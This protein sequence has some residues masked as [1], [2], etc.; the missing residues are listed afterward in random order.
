MWNIWT[1]LSPCISSY[2]LHCQER[3]RALLVHQVSMKSIGGDEKDLVKIIIF[4]TPI[5]TRP[6][7][8][9]NGNCTSHFTAMLITNHMVEMLKTHHFGFF[10]N[11]EDL[12]NKEQNLKKK[13][14]TWK[15]LISIQFQ[16]FRSN[17]IS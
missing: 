11:F 2:S 13:Q 15:Q 10:H 16:S 5:Q 3:L 4:S 17:S 1:V 9:I 6:I 12:D 8:R 7:F 14:L